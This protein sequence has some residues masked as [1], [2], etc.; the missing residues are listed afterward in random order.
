MD[1][2]LDAVD[3]TSASPRWRAL[4][5][6]LTVRR[7]LVGHAARTSREDHYVV[8]DADGHMHRV[9]FSESTGSIACE[10]KAG[11]YNK[12]CAHAGA[13]LLLIADCA[14]ERKKGVPSGD[15]S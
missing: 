7:H 13:V 11:H 1:I 8:L 3:N 9:I 6:I 14:P 12:P 5:I 15:N 10:C 2:P 4:S